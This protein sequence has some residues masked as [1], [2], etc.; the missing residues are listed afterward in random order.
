LS[1]YLIGIAVAFVMAYLVVKYFS[2][3]LSVMA[4]L[5]W[6]EEKKYKQPTAEEIDACKEKF[7]RQLLK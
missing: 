6:L 4:I 3:K 7:L 5:W 1:D 2:M